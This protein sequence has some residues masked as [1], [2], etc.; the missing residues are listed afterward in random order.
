MLP[1]D[2]NEISQ[3]WSFKAWN[4]NLFFPHKNMSQVYVYNC[5][6]CPEGR[7]AKYEKLWIEYEF[8]TVISKLFSGDNN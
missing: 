7:E 5:G 3:K 1:D 6:V 8:W 4:F 2:E